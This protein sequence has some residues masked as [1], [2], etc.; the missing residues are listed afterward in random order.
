MSDRIGT[1]M[2]LSELRGI[3]SMARA[4]SRH[5]AKSR[6]PTWAEYKIQRAK[7]ALR[8]VALKVGHGTPLPLNNPE[9]YMARANL[10]Q[11][12]ED[13]TWLSRQIKP[14]AVLPEW[15]EHQV[16]SAHADIDRVYTRFVRMGETPH[17]LRRLR[18][19][20]LK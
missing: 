4:L 5:Y 20:L 16:H 1:K 2:V 15:L 11:I 3:A 19:R 6:P 18:S 12:A 13:A 8:G 17:V 10:T 14:N 9:G 7:M